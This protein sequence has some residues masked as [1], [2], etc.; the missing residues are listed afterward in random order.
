M[1]FSSTSVHWK[2]AAL[3]VGLVAALALSSCGGAQDSAGAQTA[4]GVNVDDCTNP[5]SVNEKITGEFTLGYSAPLSGPVAGPVKLAS[6]G[7]MAR[8]DAAN[9]AGGIDGVKINVVY[10]DDGFQP[11]KAKANVTEFVESLKVDGLSTFGAGTLGAMAADQNAAC[12]PML[13]PSS[14]APEFSVIADYPWTVQFLP[15]ATSEASFAVNLIKK[16]F[17]DGVKLGVAENQTASGMNYSEAFKAAAK[18]AGLD[19]EVV[20][21]DTDPNAAATVLKAAGVNA[22]YHAGI[23][24]S[25]G[26]LDTA[27]GRIGYKPELVLKPSNCVAASEYI[28]AGAAA[29]GVKVPAYLKLVGSPDFA[30]DAGVKMYLDQVKGISDPSNAVTAS[31]WTGAD[32]LVNTLQQAAA[33]PEG[34]TRLSIIEAARDQNYASPLLIDGVM[35][36]STPEKMTGFNGFSALTWSAAEQRFVSDGTVLGIGS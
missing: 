2:Y 14:S 12:V 5:E 35:W 11:D 3:P 30:D 25:C 8:I 6:D 4:S 7:Y 20:T 24:G 21:P 22:V 28:A 26:V 15:S 31:G 32:L 33:S 27:M 9:A 16:T 17:P 23:V 34:L 18:E 1:S 13:Y 36:E 10:K 19:I 29:D